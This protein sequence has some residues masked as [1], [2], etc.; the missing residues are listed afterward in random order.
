[1]TGLLTLF[2]ALYRHVIAHL[3]RDLCYKSVRTELTEIAER[4]CNDMN[5]F[6]YTQAI[7]RPGIPAQHSQLIEM[8]LIII[9]R[10]KI[11]IS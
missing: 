8:F 10:I 1:M 5:L 11:K 3:L 2:I 7:C 4:I 9:L 6:V